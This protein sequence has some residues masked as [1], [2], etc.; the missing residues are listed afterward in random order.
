MALLSDVHTSLQSPEAGGESFFVRGSYLYY[1][2]ACD[3]FKDQGWGC[4][5]R[6][7]QSL[8]SHIRIAK[9][10]KGA[11][12]CRGDEPTLREIQE[13][14][15]AMQDKPESFVGSREWIGSF[16]VSLC[17][18]FF[19]DVSGK[20]I[21]LS[22]GS[23][24]PGIVP[25]LVKHFKTLGTAIMMGGDSDASSKGIFGVHLGASRSYLL[26]LDPHFTGHATVEELI[27]KEW[28][29]W[30]PSDSFMASSFYNLCLP[31]FSSV[32]D[33]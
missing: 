21:H 12:G 2:Y 17:L 30:K 14:L 1:H 33:G 18:D 15:V 6:T 8:C 23:D 5:Y 29:S 24:I 19:H 4:G 31:Q 26:V 22:S 3:G 16:E 25:D 32:S 28:V 11:T 7:L 20:I 27:K 9:E 10:V 13:A